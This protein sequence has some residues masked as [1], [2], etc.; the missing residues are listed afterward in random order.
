METDKLK[1]ILGMLKEIETEKDKLHDY[2]SNI[3]ISSRN[4][5]LK[6]IYED[7]INN[8]ALLEDLKSSQKLVCGGRENQASTSGVDL[9]EKTIAEINKDPTKKVF[10]LKEFIDSF[11]DISENDRTVLLNSLESTKIEELSNKMES[12]VNLFK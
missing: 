8:N 12:L 1:E 2:L 9:V 5:L 6:F 10:F 7:I 11:Q 3:N 4:D